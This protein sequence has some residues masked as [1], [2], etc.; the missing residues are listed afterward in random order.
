MFLNLFKEED[1]RKLNKFTAIEL[2]DLEYVFRAGGIEEHEVHIIIIYIYIYIYIYL[3]IFIY[4]YLQ[5][6][7]YNDYRYRQA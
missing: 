4:R 6:Y 3:Y 1:A 2:E 5:V 7:I